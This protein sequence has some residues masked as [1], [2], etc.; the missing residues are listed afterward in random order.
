MSTDTI[1]PAVSGNEALTVGERLTSFFKELSVGF[2]AFNAKNFNK[3]IHTVQGGEVWKQL[4]GSN[5]YFDVAIKHIPAPVFFDP[6]VWSFID[7]VNFVLGAVPIVKLVD[8]Q[9]DQVYR[10]IKTVAATGNVPF[11]LRSNANLTLISEAREVFKSSFVDT[12][13]YTRAVNEMYPNFA[14]AGELLTRFNSIVNTLQSRDVEIIAKRMDE[15]IR[16]TNLLKAKID[17]SEI[18]V[19]PKEAETLNMIIGELVDNASFAGMM[20]SQLSELT[21]IL[22]AQVQEARKL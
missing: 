20:L 9:A 17:A 4:A 22:Q 8:T 2:D 21:R 18:I 10:G 12:K 1:I 13:V 5:K 6:K 19:N 14:S 15:V 11:S 16:I 7:F 3:S